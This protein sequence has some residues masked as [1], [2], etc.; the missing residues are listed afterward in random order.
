MSHNK[1]EKG[2]RVKENDQKAQDQTRQGGEV[3]GWQKDKNEKRIKDE[4]R[5]EITE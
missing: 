4:E 3:G 2:D 1:E 5:Q